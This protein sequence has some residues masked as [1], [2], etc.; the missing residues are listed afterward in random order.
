MIS[1]WIYILVRAIRAL[2]WRI[3]DTLSTSYYKLVCKKIHSSS[4][5]GWGTWISCP[6]NVSIGRNVNIGRYNII[7]TERIDSKL[8]INDDVQIN[9]GVKIDFTGS[10]EIG[11]NTFISESVFIYTHSHGRNPRS[12]AT[13]HSKKIGSNVWIGARTII[14][15][16]CNFIGNGSIVGTGIVLTKSLPENSVIVGSHNRLIN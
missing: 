2:R 6:N 13:P 9:E 11:N 14:M 10:I 8:T 3:L 5:I 7:G 16:N 4:R 15:Y 12:Y 1:E